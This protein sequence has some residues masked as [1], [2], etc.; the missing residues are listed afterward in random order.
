MAT[1]IIHPMYVEDNGALVE[2]TGV[3]D[4]LRL[5]AEAKTKPA[6]SEDDLQKEYDFYM[7]EKLANK[8]LEKGFLSKEEC[9]KLSVKNREIFCPYLSELMS[10]SA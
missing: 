2:N 8:L 10:K 4:I 9:T 7:A 1:K 6:L 3:P 5:T